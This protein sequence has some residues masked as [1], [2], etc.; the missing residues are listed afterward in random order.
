METL[1]T[2]EMTFGH[3][4]ALGAPSRG[5]LGVMS[6]WGWNPQQLDEVG[7]GGPLGDRPKP[8]GGPSPQHPS[9]ALWSP[10]SPRMIYKDYQV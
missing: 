8:S 5:P 3:V 10:P 2:Q 4:G 7:N 9:Q 6:D 1:E